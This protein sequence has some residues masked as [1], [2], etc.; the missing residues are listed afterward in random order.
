LG[1]VGGFSAVVCVFPVFGFV[2]GF[3]GC[4]FACCCWFSSVSVFFG[5]VAVSGCF[6]LCCGL[7][8]FC[9]APSGAFFF[10]GGFVLLLVFRL[11]LSGVRLRARLRWLPFCRV[12]LLVFRLSLSGVRLRARLR[13]LPFCRVVLLVFRLS[14]S[15]VRL[16][17]R[18]RA[19]FGSVAA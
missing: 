5:S 10:L 11:S 16:R 8:R 9:F 7:V 19:V 1:F 12:V 6:W 2:R 13:W 14:L 15:G 18:L 4:V 17:A 3:V